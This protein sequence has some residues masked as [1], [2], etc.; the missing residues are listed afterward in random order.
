MVLF[1][2][3][4]V[5]GLETCFLPSKKCVIS[6]FMESLPRMSTYMPTDHKTTK[7]IDRKRIQLNIQT[8]Q[9]VLAL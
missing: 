4:L 8:W 3:V 1:Q 5:I 9:R 7:T 6:L 2:G